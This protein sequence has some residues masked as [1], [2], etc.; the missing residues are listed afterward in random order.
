MHVRGPRFVLQ[1]KMVSRLTM[2]DLPLD[3]VSTRLEITPPSFVNYL[4][5]RQC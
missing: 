5:P 4:T 3:F 2:V 1:K